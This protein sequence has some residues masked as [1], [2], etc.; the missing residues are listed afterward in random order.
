MSS[1][2]QFRQL[3][4]RVEKLEQVSGVPDTPKQQRKQRELDAVAEQFKRAQDSA[5]TVIMDTA[6]TPEQLE[7]AVPFLGSIGLQEFARLEANKKRSEMS[8]QQQMFQPLLQDTS[9]IENMQASVAD[10]SYHTWR[11]SL[12]QPEPEQ[13]PKRQAPK[14][15][16]GTASVSANAMKAAQQLAASQYQK[17]NEQMQSYRGPLTGRKTEQDIFQFPNPMD[18]IAR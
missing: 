2:S 14:K 7:G 4:K 6:S 16:K 8:L 15:A 18:G 11:E 1:N 10:G 12:R 17:Q 3:S 13:A 9:L 5:K